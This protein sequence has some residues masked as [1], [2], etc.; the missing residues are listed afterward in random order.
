MG[1]G[2][3]K[4][5]ITACLSFDI[6]IYYF[7]IKHSVHFPHILFI[8]KMNILGFCCKEIDIWAFRLNLTSSVYNPTLCLKKKWIWNFETFL[9][10]GTCQLSGGW[11]CAPE[12]PHGS[13]VNQRWICCR[14]LVITL[15]LV[16]VIISVLVLVII[17]TNI[18]IFLKVLFIITAHVQNI[19]VD[20]LVI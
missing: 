17:L 19:I 6:E 7:F 14:L 3:R 11:P 8:L 1:P 20:V 4:N 12:L 10:G 18:M 16:L 15:V 5:I 9:D 13:S 2:G